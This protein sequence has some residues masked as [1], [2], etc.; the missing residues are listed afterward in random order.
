MFNL[1]L[2]DASASALRKQF[3]AL[4]N[5]RHIAVILEKAARIGASLLLTRLSSEKIAALPSI[6]REAL[7]Q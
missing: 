3:F 6:Y 4:A 1:T 7:D 2:I 5:R